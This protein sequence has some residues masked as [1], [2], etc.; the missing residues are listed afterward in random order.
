MYFIIIDNKLIVTN[1][2][3]KRYNNIGKYLFFIEK[4]ELLELIL[5]I[6]FLE[7]NSKV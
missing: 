4:D 5:K 7:R 6:G 3:G 1:I 2:I